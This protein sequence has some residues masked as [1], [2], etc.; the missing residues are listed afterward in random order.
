MLLPARL[1]HRKI[2]SHKGDF[3]HIFI[4]AGCM[5][6]SGAALLCSDAAMRSGAGL[7]TL[8]VPRGIAGSI[9]KR[10]SP[11]V[12]LRPLAQSRQFTLSIRAYSSIRALLNEIDVLI[13]GPGLSRNSS[14]QSLIHRILG[15]INKPVIIDADG[16]NALC[17]R[18]DLLTRSAS[19]QDIILTPHPGEM[20][21]LS[22][23]DIVEIQRNRKDIA[24]RF[25]KQNKVI[26]VLKGYRTIVADYRGNL[27]TN[28]T[29]NA[30]MATAGSG[31]VLTGILGAFL[32]QGL[33]GFEAARY[34]VYLHGL[35]GDLAAKEKTQLGMVASDI[36]AKL[37]QAIR[38]SS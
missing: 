29:G 25:A 9:I 6:F 3:G 17:G 5:Q 21:R 23:L 7:V 16:I 15:N 4:L 33:S 34:A 38:L 11:E 35:A 24:C 31:D 32:A 1:L 10:K 30:G 27:Y 13:L 12:I 26:V 18:L 37:P 8:G 14:T 19:R 2:T 36:I 28:R 22:G 20:S